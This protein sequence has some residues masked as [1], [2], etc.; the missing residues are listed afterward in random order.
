[1]VYQGLY[2]TFG[3]DQ[4]QSP[5]ILA[6]QIVAARELGAGGFVLFE[7]QDHVITG[8]LPQLRRGITAP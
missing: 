5:D 3:P 2:T 7:L 8:L 1:P 6:A 4:S